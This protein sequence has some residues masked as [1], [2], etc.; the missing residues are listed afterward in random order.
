MS[1]NESP[2][3]AFDRPAPSRSVM[4][5]LVYDHIWAQFDDETIDHITVAAALHIDPALV[6]ELCDEL[7]EDGLLVEADGPDEDD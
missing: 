1:T 3:P 6:K 7:V 2:I 4:K 5:D